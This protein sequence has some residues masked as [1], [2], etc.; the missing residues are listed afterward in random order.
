[1]QGTETVFRDN[2]SPPERVKPDTRYLKNR[3]K[4]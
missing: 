2:G 4:F 3:L 1:M